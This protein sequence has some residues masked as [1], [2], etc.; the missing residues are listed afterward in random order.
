MILSDFKIGLDL[1]N[2]IID[3][4]KVFPFVAKKLNL[5]EQSWLGSKSD[6]RKILLSR[7]N[8]SFLWRIY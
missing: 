2:T 6:L 1:D 5:V 3:Y 8:G 7:K 4:S